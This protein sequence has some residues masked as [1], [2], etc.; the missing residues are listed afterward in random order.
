MVVEN[1]PQPPVIE[2][3]IQQAL[4]DEGYGVLAATLLNL[5]IIPLRKQWTI[6]R[7]LAKIILICG[8]VRGSKSYTANVFFWSHKKWGVPELFW[9][10]GAN[11]TQCKRM[12]NYIKDSAREMGVLEPKGTTDR[13]DPGVIKLVDGTTIE[14]RSGTQ[15]ETWASEALDGIIIDEAAQVT[16]DLY[17]RAIERLAEKKGWLL[18]VGTLE[19]SL[20]WYSK[21]YE[22]WQ[23]GIKSRDGVLQQQSFS[24]PTWENTYLFPGGRQDPEILLMEQEMGP[25][26]FKERCA[27]EPVP[28]AGLVFPEVR[29]DIHVERTD[30]DPDLPVLMGIDPGYSDSCAYE[31]FQEH[32]GQLRGFFEVYERG[33]TVDWVI[34]FIQS[35]PFWGRC[36]EKGGPGIYAAGDLYGGQHHHDRT[37]YEVWQEKTGLVVDSTKI[38]DVNDV[39]AQI[40][41]YLAFDPVWERTRTTFDPS[42]KGILS[43]FGIG[44]EPHDNVYRSYRW[45]MTRDGQIVGNKPKDANNHGS[46]AFGYL[47]INKF[48]FAD[49]QNRKSVPVKYW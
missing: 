40:H 43:N 42:M 5:K 17:L 3:H 13:W 35:Q 46:K 11:Y 6:L 14:T 29:A 1:P 23:G 25:E 20:G 8:G 19:Q 47:I 49:V 9:I 22:M 34:D 38:T 30:F 18:L 10:G 4:K 15:P 2:E 48:G 16:F 32:Q 26:R 21:L 12:F 33:R 39:D 28:P 41:R 36:M 44:P 24:L 7:C 37:V 31:F 45:D 27:G